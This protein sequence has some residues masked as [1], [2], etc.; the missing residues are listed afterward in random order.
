MREFLNKYNTVIFDMDGV[1]TS[2]EK[3]WDAAAL[4]VWEY[5]RFCR[6]E[7]ISAPECMAKVREIRKIVFCDDLLIKTLK[8]KGVN[9]NWDLGYVT[10]LMAWILKTEDFVKVLEYA[11]TLP[12]NIIEVYDSLAR[13]CADVTGYDYKWLCRNGLM[14]QTM[15]DIFQEWYLGEQTWGKPVKNSGKAGLMFSEKPI[16]NK[17]KL[18]EL[19]AE[20]STTHRLCTGTG[21]PFNEMITPLNQWGVT[22][23]F[24][25]N[26]LANYDMV[27][28]AEREL[29]RT[30]TKPHPYIFL[31]ALYGVDHD[32]KK[33]I[34][35]EYDKS[36]ISKALIVGD[37]GADILAAREMGADFCAVLTGVAGKKAK[38]Y[39]QKM[40][41]QYIIDSVLDLN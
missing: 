24:D 26:G 37:A 32:D 35:G 25:K 34:D 11:K 19:L 9:S 23:Y 39:F 38:D 29:G 2:E 14:W 22:D 21:R 30:L 33:I 15:H 18:R 40:N 13:E 12:D 16:V 36:E 28:V 31:K 3:Y 5:L 6:D 4:T 20:L 17:G 27:E 7:S 8:N 1:I 10:V 41:A